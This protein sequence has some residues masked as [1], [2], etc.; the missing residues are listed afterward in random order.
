MS[1]NGFLVFD[2]CTFDN[3]NNDV[4]LQFV[5]EQGKIGAV[6]N[7]EA[8]GCGSRVEVCVHIHIYTYIYMAA[9]HLFRC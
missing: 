6:E 2:D 8:V 7:L 1:F 4:P 5:S 9:S 3:D